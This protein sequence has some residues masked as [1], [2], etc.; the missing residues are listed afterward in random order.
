MDEKDAGQDAGM[1]LD[2]K[3]RGIPVFKN[4][5]EALRLNPDYCVVGVATT[6]GIFHNSMS[7]D[8]KQ[9]I[10]N[11]ISI[12]NGL[13]DYLTERADIVELAEKSGARLIDIRKPKNR[14]DL[15]FWTGDIFKSKAIIAVLGTN[16]SMG[17]H[18]TTRFLLN[19]C[20]AEG[21]NAQMIYTGQTSWLQGGKYG[22]IFDSTFN[23][24]VSGELENAVLKGYG[25]SELTSVRL[26]AQLPFEVDV[27]V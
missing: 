17:R 15:S 4:I 7:M 5:A 22:N 16:C 8:V 24:F 20:Q 12:V 27:L 21:I 3:H 23:D 14:K 26:S 11:K 10:E 6:G 2:G 1:L 13:H 18:T 19:D 25:H 9:A